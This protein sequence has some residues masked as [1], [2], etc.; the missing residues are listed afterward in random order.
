LYVPKAGDIKVEWSRQLPSVP[1]SVT[2]I[3]EPDGRYYASFVVERETVPLPSG[4][5]EI[6]ID[7][8]LNMLMKHPGRR[9]GGRAKRL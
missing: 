7:L 6:G 9:A 8:G 4:D 2:V 5:R 1:S 3:R